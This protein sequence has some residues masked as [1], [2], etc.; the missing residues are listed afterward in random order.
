VL[1]E[2][3]CGTAAGDDLDAQLREAGRELG[4][5]LLVERTGARSITRSAP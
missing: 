3:V 4:E 5:P 2:M 1:R